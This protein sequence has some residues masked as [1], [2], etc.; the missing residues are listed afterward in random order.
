M[1]ELPLNI[2]DREQNARFGA[3]PIP[4]KMG[5][6]L[7][8]RGG[9]PAPGFGGPAAPGGMPN[10]SL[11][12]GNVSNPLLQRADDVDPPYGLLAKPQG[13]LP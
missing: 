6:A 7:G 4:G 11:F 2:Q 1:T 10:K 3:P 9:F 12:I 8:E 5:M 13:P